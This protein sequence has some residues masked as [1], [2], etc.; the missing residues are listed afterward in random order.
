MTD[1]FRDDPA[2]HWRESRVKT[3]TLLQMEAVE[4]GA[5]ALGIVLGHFGRLEPLEKLRVDC[6]VSRDGSKAGNMVRAA[7][8]Y[9]LEAQGYRLEPEGLHTLPLPQILFWNFNHFV[10]L[11]GIKGE[12]VFLNDP[13]LGPR[14]VTKEELDHS[15]TGVVMAFRPGPRFKKGGERRTLARS[16]AERLRGFRVPVTYSLL[17][18]LSLMVPG[19]VVP[20]FSKMFVDDTLIHNDVSWSNPLLAAMAAALGII[21]LLTLLQQ[22]NLLRFQSKLAVVTSASF[23]R[24]IMRLP[25]EFFSQ[26]FG[27]EIASRV[28]INDRVAQLLSGDLASNAI[29]VVTILLY[30]ILMFQYDVWLTF[31]GVFIACF[32]L[33]ALGYV[34]KR[35]VDLNQRFL[36]EEGKL[37]GT[38]INGLQQIETI[39]ATGAEP[40]LF[41]RWAGYQAK[42][43]NAEQDLGVPTYFLMVIPPLLTSLN[44]LGILSLGALRV[45]Q[46]ELSMGDLVAFQAL[47]ATFLAPVNQLVNLGPKLQDAQG[48]MNRLDDVFNNPIDERYQLPEGEDGMQD[49]PVE[50]RLELRNITFGYSPLAPPLIENFDLAL[51]PGDRVALVGNSGSGKSTVA[52]LAAGLFKPWGGEI[53]LDGRP[54][55]NTPRRL[56][57]SAMAVVDQEIFMFE[58]SIRDNLTL[59][60]TSISEEDLVKAARDACIHDMIVARSGGYDSMVAEGGANFSG[61]QR[62]RLEIARALAGSPS[63]L[64]LDE[65]TSALDP[66]TEKQVMD[67][68]HRRGCTC[69]IV[70]HRLS[71]IRDSNEIIML[72]EGRVK[73]RGTHREMIQLDGPYSQL[74][75]AD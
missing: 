18:G 27:G 53:L 35:R 28:M 29:S 4:C 61:G 41:A 71:T 39:K 21:Y 55:S 58:G 62:Q 65:A 64:I 6:G 74:I 38:A 73:Q 70:A 33:V 68:I 19:L 72:Q 50:G 37:L 49:R 25:L 60:N 66:S 1:S 12:K 69:L 36:Q 75:K 13:A 32:N 45:M 67:N 43:V 24:H 7:R 5:A 9:G 16:L 22:T 2:N 59:W 23:L 34:S 17:V 11:E 10:V 42:V 57:V 15:F 30:T 8:K 47:M 26:R 31:T 56:L 52:K 63:V 54:L 20:I 40:D 46:G 51:E 3:P 48:D 14:V 44:N